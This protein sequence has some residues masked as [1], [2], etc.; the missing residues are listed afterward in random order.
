MKILKRIVIA[1]VVLGAL[2][3][4]VGMPLA[5]KQTKKHSPETT[6]SYVVNGWDLRTHYSAPSKK[7]RVIFGELVPFGKV[8]RTGANEPTTFAT[9]QDIKII[10]K[11]LP[12]GIYSLWT[13]PGAEEW[14]IYFNSEVPDW[15]VTLASGGAETTRNPKSDVVQ[16]TVPVTTTNPK[17]QLTLDFEEDGAL[18]L[19]IHWDTQK[20][21]IP[22]SK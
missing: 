11:P 5:R 4:F 8:W 6:A 7:D 9:T 18:Y 17:E 15:G 20:I 10:D 1:V 14:E 21:R 22:L 16:V 3:Y 13:K 12:A 2:L 19:Y